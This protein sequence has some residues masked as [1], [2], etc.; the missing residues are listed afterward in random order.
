LERGSHAPYAITCGIYGWFLH[1]RFL[2]TESEG[3]KEYAAMQD[4]LAAILGMIPLRT[5]PEGDA[6][7]EAVCE[8]ISEFVKKFPT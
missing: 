3:L 1:T 6:K 4:V 8:A 2:G 5:D 7:S